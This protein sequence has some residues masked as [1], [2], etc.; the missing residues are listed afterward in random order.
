MRSRRAWAVTLATLVSGCAFDWDALRYTPGATPDTGADAPADAVI[1]VAMDAAD[2]A[3]DRASPDAADATDVRDATD[4][5]DVAQDATAD[6][7]TDVALDLAPDV[8]AD[9]TT[10]VAPD[11][12]ADIAPDIAPDVPLDAA[13]DAA[14][15][16]APD[17][18]ACTTLG[19]TCPCSAT[20]SGGYCRPGEAC[21]GGRCMAMTLAGSLVITEIMNDPNTPVTDDNGEW[22]E[23]YNPGATPLDLRGL[24]ISNSRAETR[25]VAAS[26]PVL[27]AAGG[28]AVFAR[29]ADTTMNGGVTATF[30]YASAPGSGTI[31][32]G[33]TADA[34]IVDLGSSAMELDRVAYDGTTWPRTSGHAKSLR[35][36]ALTATDNDMVGNWCNAPRQWA[37]GD[38]GSPGMANPACP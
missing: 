12:A 26:T 5:R 6:V 16:V 35:P 2:A 17:A 18:P 9:V 32:F 4:A 25:T 10:D 14:P 11:V 33:N 29:I 30:A 7:A 36:T 27:I 8:A 21:T 13:P 37:S 28:Y 19:M 1:D 20:N 22:F 31:N 3:A 38:Y 24:R 23:V 15:D 34:V